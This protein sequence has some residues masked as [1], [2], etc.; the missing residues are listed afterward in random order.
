METIYC[1]LGSGIDWK[2]GK[3][4]DRYPNNYMNLPPA[5]GGQGVWSYDHGRNDS[6]AE[7]FGDDQEGF[8]RFK[9]SMHQD[10]IKKFESIKNCI[11]NI[12]ERCHKHNIKNRLRWYPISW[13]SCHLCVPHDAQEDFRNG[14]I[15]TIHLIL[16]TEGEYGTKEWIELQRTKGYAEKIL[17]ALKMVR[18]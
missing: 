7:I 15:E 2:D 8:E 18:K 5:A 9:E 11:D 14:A 16:N 17:K 13:Y 12:D 3:L 10:S 1:L 6:I 4:L